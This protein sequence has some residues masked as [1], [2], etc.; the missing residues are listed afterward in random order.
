ME[1]SGVK[2]EPTMEI[3]APPRVDAVAGKICETVRDE[4]VEPGVK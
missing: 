3:I 2:F 1:V 4:A